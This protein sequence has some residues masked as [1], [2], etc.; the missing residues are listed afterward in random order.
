MKITE[1]KAEKVLNSLSRMK[2]LVQIMDFEYNTEMPDIGRSQLVRNHI[3]RIR[4]SISEINTNL[5]HLVKPKAG[6]NNDL[7]DDFSAELMDL[8]GIVSLMD[9]E[10]IKAF[11]NDLKNYIESR[12]NETKRLQKK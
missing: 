5:N 1:E 9:L 12:K 7:L 10:S 11:N 2:L 8:I 6:I 4:E 3:K